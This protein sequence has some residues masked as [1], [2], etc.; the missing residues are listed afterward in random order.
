MY[1]ENRQE[2]LKVNTSNK[3][4][5]IK[6]LGQPHSKSL[7]EKNTWIYIERTK[8]KGKIYKLGRDVLVNNNVLVVKFD[9]RGILQEKLFYNKDNMKDNLKKIRSMENIYWSNRSG[10]LTRCL[11]NWDNPYRFNIITK[12]ALKLYAEHDFKRVSRMGINRSHKVGRVHI[13]K[14]LMEEPGLLDQPGNEWWD[15]YY[16]NDE[17]ILATSTENRKVDK[18]ELPKENLIKMEFEK[19]MFNSSGKNNY[20]HN[21]KEE[22]YLRKL[23][24]KVMA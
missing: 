15:Y 24:E 10:M 12:D 6:R 16:E 1:L 5:V 9:N 3:N 21:K 11:E 13:H 18:G 2:L 8:T 19:G 20:S 17:C 4:D 23:Y 14:K 7:K 22:E